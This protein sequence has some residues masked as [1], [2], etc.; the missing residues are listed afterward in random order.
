MNVCIRVRED[1]ATARCLISCC[2]LM[3]SMMLRQSTNICE[4]NG[5]C[6]HCEERVENDDVRV[7]QLRAFSV[8]VM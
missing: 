1:L 7:E 5:I 4:L 3:G 6:A 8:E 2:F